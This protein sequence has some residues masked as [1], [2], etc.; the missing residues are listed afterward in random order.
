MVESLEKEAEQLNTKMAKMKEDLAKVTKENATNAERASSL[1][2][3]L[4]GTQSELQAE[5]KLNEELKDRVKELEAEL[6][7]KLN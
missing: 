7:S 4:A 3:E 1:S 6:S 2:K 5:I